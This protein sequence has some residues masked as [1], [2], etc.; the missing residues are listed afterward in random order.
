MSPCRHLP[1]TVLELVSTLTLPAAT[2]AHR[3][4][5]VTEPGHAVWPGP[6]ARRLWSAA[7][8]FFL[9][10]LSPDPTASA[11]APAPHVL[12]GWSSGLSWAPLSLPPSSP[13]ASLPS[14]QPDLPL[15]RF[16][17]PLGS[18]WRGSG[19]AAPTYPSSRCL[20]LALCVSVGRNPVSNSRDGS[21][22]VTV[23]FGLAR[24]PGSCLAGPQ[25]LGVI[26]GAA[27]PS[28]PE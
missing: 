2:K 6:S 16:V 4:S 24:E 15:P 3:R 28:Q 25:G 5:L 10:L 14:A 13:A 8:R 11:V 7:P 9:W 17:Y 20:A 18:S 12:P 27:V 23:S 19:S 21:E 26:L 22:Q 1:L